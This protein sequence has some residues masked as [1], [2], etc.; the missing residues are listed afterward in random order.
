MLLKKCF[1]VILMV[2]IM[3]IPVSTVFGNSST[4][5]LDFDPD[6]NYTDN[7]TMTLNGQTITYRAY[8]N[9]VYVK[10]PVDTT[11]QV[12]NIYVPETYYQGKSMNGY[13]VD[14]APIFMP[15]MI[16]GYMAGLPASP[17]I[18]TQDS[19][20]GLNATF[21]ALSKGY[22]VA[23]PGVRGR[24]LQNDSGQ[25]TGK[26]PACIVD[27]KAAVRYL[28][29][30]A[31][32]LPGNVEKIISDGTSAGGGVSSLLG[33]TGNSK[34]YEPYLMEIGAANARD[35]V[36]ATVAY[37]PITNLDNA[38]TAYEW[39]FHGINNYSKTEVNFDPSGTIKR[40]RV[41]STL[42]AEEIKTSDELKAAFPS[43]LNGLGL[44][45]KY[46]TQLAVDANGDGTF[47][48]YVK[49][50][51]MA[52]AQK[53]YNSGTI[54]KVVID[55]KYP[56]IKM[57]GDEVTDIDWLAYCAHVGRIK[58]PP[59]FDDLG[60][61]SFENMEF[62]DEVIKAKHFTRY[63]YLHNTNSSNL[64]AETQIV[65]MM[66]PMNYIGTKGATTSRYWRI[67]WGEK[68][69]NTSIAIPVILAVKL[70]NSGYDVD[71]DMPWNQGHGGDYDLEKLFAW[72][73]RV[74]NTNA[75]STSNTVISKPYTEETLIYRLID[76]TG[77]KIT[78]STFD[79]YFG[80]GT[81][82]AGVISI[83]N[84]GQFYINGSQV[85]YKTESGGY[86]STEFKVNNT[87]ELW[88]EADGTWSWKAHKLYS[89]SGLD[90]ETARLK[91]IEAASQLEG[92]TMDVMAP[93]GTTIA[94]KIVTT[95]KDASVVSKISVSGE[96][97]IVHG[98]AWRGS[99]GA[100]LGLEPFTFPTAN[101]DATIQAGDEVLYW[102]DYESGWNI[103][104]AIPVTGRLSPIAGSKEALFEGKQVIDAKITR[105]W[106]AEEY[107]YTQF[108][109][110]QR[111]TKL[112][113]YEVIMWTTETGYVIGF[114][115]GDNAR[116]SLAQAIKY[117]EDATSAIVTSV[118]GK[119]VAT[120]KYWVTSDV[121]KAYQGALAAAK[122]MYANANATNLE[123][124]SMIFVL[125]NALG[126][127]EG[128]P[129][130]P[131]VI[132]SKALGTKAT[133]VSI[134]LGDALE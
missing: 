44:K 5:S 108:L 13:N 131:G 106:L 29:Y 103:K 132:G 34:D 38:D 111:R 87:K 73:D 96:N 12:M 117:A 77:V 123:V 43:Y 64:M 41:L 113:N 62:G 81:A 51:V 127:T 27:L 88:Q 46:F 100:G 56:W 134:I 129:N 68:D 101:V 93:I 37:C 47:K 128:A 10:H 55:S 90:F 32:R 84:A 72:I 119:D 18:N 104:R 95:I 11:Y 112:W 82:K 19:S 116:A 126:G 7:N 79:K 75:N 115:R 105:N 6:S 74:C 120:D 53:A 48:E 25:Y 91:Y 36:F 85:P 67:R 130:P 70:Q 83:L 109:R 3:F 133:Q 30:N 45:D 17:G 66:N 33:A 4:Y 97:T 124:D 35:D 122:N 26:A 15:N 1:T 99:E 78:D 9:L 92:L 24:N 14:T 71:F 89:G 54:T 61:S 59:A 28:R 42:T 118:D 58:A 50:Y 98:T 86:S 39:W 2:C 76:T 94:N 107:R 102:Y 23:A 110:G 21:V 114:T 20:G 22:V 63:G 8:T 52:A 121:W 65:K 31:A 60:I 16:G 125:G 40:T 49:S 69:S 57:T 80:D